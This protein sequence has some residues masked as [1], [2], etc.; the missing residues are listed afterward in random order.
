MPTVKIKGYSIEFPFTPYPSQIITIQTILT[1]LANNESSLIESPTGTGKTLSILCSVLAFKHKNPELKIYICSRTHK[2][3]DQ[4]I[5]ELKTTSY[6]PKITI[7]AS[8]NQYC[9]HP[10]V[11]NENDKTKSCKDLVKNN[12]CSYFKNKDA[13]NKTQIMDIEEL[14]KE[15]KRLQACPFYYSRSQ[16]D[17]ADVIFAPYNY[18]IDP[19]IRNAMEIKLNNSVVIVDEAHNIEDF[20][21]SAGTLKLDAKLIDFMGGEMLKILKKGFLEDD[22]KKGLFDV[23][24]LLKRVKEIKGVETS[25]K[26]K[27]DTAWKAV[28]ENKNSKLS[29]NPRMSNQKQSQHNIQTNDALKANEIHT[30][31]AIIN[32]LDNLDITKESVLKTKVTL[33]KFSKNDD[34]KDMLSANTFQ[35]LE[36]LVFILE[37][38]LFKNP[39]SYSM[40]VQSKFQDFTLN[41]FLLDPGV[42]F[43]PIAAEVKSI[44]LLSGT[45]TP[46]KTFSSELG[47]KFAH[48][49]EAPH[50]IPSENVFISCIENG[51]LKKQLIGKYK[52]VE[53]KEYTSQLKQIIND[54]RH[55]V[56][57]KGGILIFVP[58]YSFLDK[59]EKLLCDEKDVFF[60]PSNG[61]KF[62]RVFTNYKKSINKKEGPVFA[63]VFRGRASEGMDFKDN[64]ARAVII[65]GIPFPS[66]MDLEVLSKRQYNDNYKSVNGRVWYEIQAFRAVNQA[67]G[68]VVRHKDDWGGVFLLDCRYKEERSK[69]YLSKWVRN[70]LKIYESL[71]VCLSDFDKFIKH[72]E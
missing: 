2:Q 58:S 46:F 16:V 1:S 48:Q 4:I 23:L 22:D 69:G 54:V 39:F 57:K 37:N 67:I 33:Q 20:C 50:V 56:N 35:S 40:A 53:S 26:T 12:S 6:K 52:S 42:I 28:N 18:I 24:D 68:R 9:I 66:F 72:R 30:G 71:S 44:I 10:L 29:S 27:I 59:M 62:D 47:H 31:D 21:R 8:R 45:L 51:H 61:Q 14:T 55:K 3:I 25:K 11:K 64:F 38:I 7:L 5:S 70:N 13:L 60:E 17:K 49:V 15:G 63:C 36:T 32:I 43:V 65:I 41:F 34:L 19:G